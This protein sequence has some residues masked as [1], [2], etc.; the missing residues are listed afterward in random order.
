MLQPTFYDYIF[1]LPFG[2]I[3][4]FLTLS[5]FKNNTISN[6]TKS[7]SNDK[8]K[9]KVKLTKKNYN[10]IYL[11]QIMVL[12]FLLFSQNLLYR[13]YTDTL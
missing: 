8:K 4:L 9:I 12:L 1:I 13:G 3:L 11:K 7:V 10:F 6:L 2:L 5:F